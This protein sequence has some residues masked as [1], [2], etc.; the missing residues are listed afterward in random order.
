VTVGGQK[1]RHDHEHHPHS[2]HDYKHSPMVRIQRL[3]MFLE[4]HFGEVEYHMPDEDSETEQEGLVTSQG[5]PSFLIQLDDAEARINL[6]SMARS[7][8]VPYNVHSIAD[9]SMHRLSIAAARRYGDVSRRSSR[10]Q[11]PP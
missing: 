10:W 6:L 2:D 4:A 7:L 9:I 11:Y 8:A 5:E 3:G 1:H